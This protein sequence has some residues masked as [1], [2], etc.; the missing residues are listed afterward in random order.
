MT[1]IVRMWKAITG[2]SQL[3]TQT[4]YCTSYLDPKGSQK[5]KEALLGLLVLTQEL[6]PEL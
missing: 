4:A 5:Y 3:P 6:L 1:E 2:H